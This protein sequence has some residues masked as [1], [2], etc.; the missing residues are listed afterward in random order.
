MTGIF[1]VQDDITQG[2]VGAVGGAYGVLSRAT[3]EQSKRKATASLDAY[4]CVLRTYEY[5]TVTSEPEHLKVRGCLER[6]VRLDPN[7]AEAWALLSRVYVDEHQQGFNPRPDS[8]GRA[9]EAARRAI[10]LDP[11]DQRAHEALAIVAFFQRD[12]EA[13]FPLAE[14]AVALNPNHENTLA[15][16]GTMIV[17][18]NWTNPDKRERGLALVKKAMALN[19]SHPDWYRMPGAWVHWWKGE[20]GEALT[21]A[22][23]IYMPDYFWSHKLLAVIYAELGRKEEAAAAV[24]NVLK[25]RP[26]M[27]VTVRAEWRKWNVP[28]KVIDRAIA[29]LRR[30]GMNIPPDT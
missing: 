20:Y 6:S 10:A 23:R 28:E 9:R 15:E 14:R 22:K 2:V 27:P 24:A 29:D 17:Y 7:Y 12:L 30:A 26:D 13:F 5:W 1:E 25:L 11:S 18:S 16:M 4:E 3:L 8:L 21:E 19:P